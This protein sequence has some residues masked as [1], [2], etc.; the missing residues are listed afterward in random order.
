MTSALSQAVS[1]IVSIIGSLVDFCFETDYP[2]MTI[3]IGAVLLG[4]LMID[5]GWTYLDYFMHSTI[6]EAE[7]SISKL[8]QDT[9]HDHSEYR[10]RQPGEAAEN[11]GYN[12]TKNFRHLVSIP[13]PNL[14]KDSKQQRYSKRGNDEAPSG[15]KCI[16][17][18]SYNRSD[19]T[20]KFKCFSHSNHL[21]V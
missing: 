4:F 14:L 1:F 21:P 18:R 11:P 7:H 13:V 16:N 9:K 2:G 3:T 10:S 12:S 15:T 5:L 6:P 8:D 19:Q 20:D 17:Q